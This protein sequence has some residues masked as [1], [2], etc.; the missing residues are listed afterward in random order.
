MTKHE[1]LVEYVEF[2]ESL[3]EKP[4]KAVT[5]GELV[6]TMHLLLSIITTKEDIHGN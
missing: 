6:H 4:D 1:A 5:H 3:T 2:M